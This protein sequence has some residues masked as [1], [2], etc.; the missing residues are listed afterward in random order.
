[1]KTYACERC[2]ARVF[3]ENNSCES[4]EAQLGFV[5]SEQTMASFEEMDGRLKRVAGAGVFSRC[6]NAVEPVRCNWVVEGAAGGLCACCS[7]TRTHPALPKPENGDYWARIETAKRRLMYSLIGMGLPFPSKDVDPENGLAFDFLEQLDPGH[8]VL[9]G[10]DSGVITL[11]IAEA[12]DA[13]REH[14]RSQMHEPYRTLLGHFRHEIG[15]YY[16]DRLV[17]G[18]PWEAR[19]RELFGDERKDYAQA[20]QQHYESPMTDWEQRFISAYAS[21]HP[22]E[23]WAESWAHYMHLRDGLETAVSWGLSLA[24]AVPGQGAL[25]ATSLPAGTEPINST[26]VASWLPIS[27][28]VNAMARSLGGRDNYPFVMPDAVLIKLDFVHQVIAAASRGDFAMNFAK[29]QVVDSGATD[30]ALADAAV[31]I[32]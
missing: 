22:W 9:T 8:N 30:I 14:V 1:M 16:W 7:T 19:F 29:P 12:D 20:L 15:H 11:N 26:V 2:G 10:H 17:A 27:Q 18:T 4:C 31:A 6:S 13:H 21:S 5:P 32:A 25:T 28:F 3:F 23:D 24:N